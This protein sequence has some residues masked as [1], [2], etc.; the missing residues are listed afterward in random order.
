MSI[1]MNL[2]FGE[3]AGA[4]MREQNGDKGPRNILVARKFVCC[5]G[6]GFF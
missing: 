5:A 3:G 4:V 6:T 1:F 2:E